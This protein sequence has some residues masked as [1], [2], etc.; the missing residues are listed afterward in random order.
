MFI[1]GG[2]LT[3]GDSTMEAR[4]DFLA[5]TE[6]RLIS[7]RVR[8]EW[9]RQ[10]GKGFASVWAPASQGSS[11]VGDAGGE[12]VGEVDGWVGEWERR[13]QY[14]GCACFFACTCHSSV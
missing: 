5:V 4:V 12:W 3:H 14:E 6:H 1:V 11:R 7:A 8:G 10:K 13:C 2:W 9:V